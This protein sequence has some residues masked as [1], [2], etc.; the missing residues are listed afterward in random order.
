MISQ[1]GSVEMRESSASANGRARMETGPV[2]YSARLMVRR[3][4]RLLAFGSLEELRK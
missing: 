2:T 1:P 4:W 3:F